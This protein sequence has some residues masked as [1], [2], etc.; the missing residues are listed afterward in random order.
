GYKIRVRSEQP[1]TNVVDNGINLT[2]NA[3]PTV[4]ATNLPASGSIPN[5]AGACS[6][7]VTFGDNVSTG[8]PSPTLVYSLVSGDFS[9]PITS[10]HIFPVGTTTVYVRATNSCGDAFSSFS[11]TVT[12]DEA[13][14]APTIAD[15]TGECSATATVPTT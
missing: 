11:V 10:P 2:V 5:A 7:S 4:S 3:L 13:P 15:A 9:S 12:D 8:A 14:L 1:A 6:A